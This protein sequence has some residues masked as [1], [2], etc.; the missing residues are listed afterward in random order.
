MD[1]TCEENLIMGE[2]GGGWN[3]LYKN[4]L[5]ELTPYNVVILQAKEKYGILR[6]YCDPC[7]EEIQTI[8]DRYDDISKTICEMCGKDGSL[9]E[10]RGNW[11]K[12]ICDICCDKYSLF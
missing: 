11:L 6:V 4:L 5:D 12:T 7:T 1:N 3:N 10:L 8:L 2:F 9:R